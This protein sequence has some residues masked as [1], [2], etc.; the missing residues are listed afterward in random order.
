MRR[1]QVVQLPI[2]LVTSAE[3]HSCNRVALEDVGD[4]QDKDMATGDNDR[5]LR[6]WYEVAF[7]KIGFGCESRNDA[8]SLKG[9]GSRTTKVA[10]FGNGMAITNYVV[11]WENDGQE[12]MEYAS[13][14]TAARQARL[15]ES[16]ITT[17]SRAS[18][19]QHI[20]SSCF[21]RD[22]CPERASFLMSRARAVLHRGLHPELLGLLGF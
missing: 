1:F 14:L 17:F 5:F 21:R 11:N 15:Q 19:G 9:S 22:D 20:S 7:D 8:A 10:S 6:L 13:T 3:T 12:I 2:G 18:L 4:R 16:L